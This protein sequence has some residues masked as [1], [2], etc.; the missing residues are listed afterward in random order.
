MPISMVIVT[1]MFIFL[2][3]LERLR[4]RR[5]PTHSRWIRWRWNLVA[6][7]FAQ[8]AS[9]AC[10]FVLVTPL[11]LWSAKNGSGWRGFVDAPDWLKTGVSLVALDGLL[12]LWHR[13]NHEVPFLWRWHKFHH[14]DEDMDVSTALRF[15]PVELVLSAVF[16]APFILLLGLS[17][18]EVMVFNV[19]VTCAAIFHHADLA[20]G[21]GPERVLSRLCITPGLH[22][23]HHA[24]DSNLRDRNYGV[25][26][27][28]WDRLFRTYEPG[29]IE[30]LR[31]LGI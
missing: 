8:I 12:Y 20:L 25:F 7:A 13:L 17:L 28:L 15:H 2:A 23:V 18:G 21:S 9:R 1:L 10:A 24:S 11:L 29:R 30:P 3:A 22:E 31:N 5:S 6:F 16:H 27:T 26:T 19:A 4:V 14:A